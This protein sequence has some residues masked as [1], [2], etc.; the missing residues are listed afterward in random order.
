MLRDPHLLEGRQR[1]QDGASDPYA[2]FTLWGSNDLDLH[3][4]WSQGSDFLLHPVGNTREHG[5]TSGENG[6]GVQVFTDVHVALHDGVVCG[7]VDTSGFHSQERWLE[8]SLWATEPL[9]SDGDNLS[10]GKLVALLQAGAGSSSAHLLFEVQGNV[11]ELLLDVTDDFTFGSGG[12]RVSTFGEDLH[13]VIGQITSSQV[14]TEDGVGKGVSLV[15]GDGVGDTI[16][17]V[18]HDTGGTSRSV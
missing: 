17:R 11:A 13:Q 4:W 15:D 1:S 2:V 14:Q 16:T 18:E 9:V 12:E 3:G 5:A 7:L 8:E 10:V 6:V